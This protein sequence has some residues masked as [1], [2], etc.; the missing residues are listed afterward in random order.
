M[1]D[2]DVE[3]DSRF[4]EPGT[5]PTSWAET[6]Q[7][8]A[9]AQMF[10]ISTTRADSR[11]HVSPLVAVWVDDAL[12][13]CTGPTE[14]KAL[15]LRANHDVVLTTGANSWDKGLDVVV[16]GTAQRVV[17][18]TDLDRLAAAWARKWDGRWDYDVTDVGF[19]SG[20]HDAAHVFSVRPT[21]ILA[22]GKNPFTHT[23]YRF[24]SH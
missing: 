20:D 9:N 23:R 14:Q 11:P 6:E 18:R 19:G 17:G 12:H 1:S 16:S 2:P 15:N 10:W 8:I 3:L 24:A 13:F 5:S 4:S 21:K 7:T 22:F